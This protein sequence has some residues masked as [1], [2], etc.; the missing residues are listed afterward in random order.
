M[1]REA[2]APYRRRL[3]PRL[4]RLK[5]S[6]I[7]AATSSRSGILRARGHRPARIIILLEHHLGD[8]QDVTG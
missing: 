1:R 2:D 4:H 5:V 7:G 6:G 8:D 3:G